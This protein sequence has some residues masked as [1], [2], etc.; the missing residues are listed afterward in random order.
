MKAENKISIPVLGFVIIFQITLLC[1]TTILLLPIIPDFLYNTFGEML[2]MFILVGFSFLWL[3]LG[4]KIGN[5]I[6]PKRN[7]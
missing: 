7:I 5:K 6:F 2:A 4:M 3:K 1:I